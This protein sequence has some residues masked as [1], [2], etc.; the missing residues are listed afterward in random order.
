MEIRRPRLRFEIG[1]PALIR[2]VQFHRIDVRDYTALIEPPPDDALSIR[3]KER[4]AVV[5]RGGSEPALIRTIRVHDVDVA[6]V[7]RIGFIAFPIFGGKFLERV[8]STE[9]AED[10][11]APVWRGT[12]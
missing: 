10:D 12:C 4:P 8:R 2:A 3:R 7:S 1:E 9:R 11:L 5:T 6:E